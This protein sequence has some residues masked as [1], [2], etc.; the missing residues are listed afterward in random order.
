MSESQLAAARWM[1]EAGAGTSACTLLRGVR[2]GRAND[3]REASEAVS[4]RPGVFALVTQSGAGL[5]VPMHTRLGRPTTTNAD[6]ADACGR[7]LAAAR[8]WFGLGSLPA[9]KLEAEELFVVSGTSLGLPAA[10]AFAFH[11]ASL[12]APPKA[13]LA[14]GSLDEEGRVLPVAAWSE[15][16]IAADAEKGDRIVL[17]PRGQALAS[18]HVEVDSASEAFAVCLGSV[19][20]A[21]P[22]L[23]ALDELIE[24]A[25]AEADPVRKTELLESIDLKA[26]AV[27]DR[28][29][30]VLELGTAARHCGRT[31]RAM[32]LHA[33]AEALLGPARAVIGLESA[34]RFVLESWLTAMD[35]FELSSARTALEARLREP[36]ATVA[37]ELRCRGMLA[38]A[39]AMDDRAAEA[40]AVR[41]Q[42]LPL[43]SLRDALARMRP[44]TLCCLV[45]DAARAS[46]AARF[47]RYR[48]ELLAETGPSDFHQWRHVASAVVR[49]FVSLGRPEEAI[50][51]AARHGV[52][53]GDEPIEHHPETTVARA[54]IRAHRRVGNLR[55]AIAIG[56]RCVVRAAEAPDLSAWL[57]ALAQLELALAKRE[58][59]EEVLVLVRDALA[60]LHPP[61]TLHHRGLVEEDD[62]TEVERA[63]D[64]VYY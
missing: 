31:D 3:V 35:R 62:I 16:L 33:R 7:G 48:G 28:A 59:G 19:K 40:V 26:L 17:V 36:F 55:G 1:I 50:A 63:I 21:D 46:D 14:T 51:W 60:R 61:A 2:G 39:L 9:L 57:A 53:A 29:R 54:L 58:D 10:I 43:H 64:R 5:V 15:K 45:R 27:A 4:L 44:G 18:H 56:A 20:T 38:Q 47:E 34:E 22:R 42:N 32:E 49:G 6:V 30:V 11:F 41:E 23:V 8:A 12:A 13:I 52:L 37:N 24:R 25:R